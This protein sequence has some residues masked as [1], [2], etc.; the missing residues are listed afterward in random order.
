MTGGLRTTALQSL[1][2]LPP[3]N[4]TGRGSRMI[5]CNHN[6]CPVLHEQ[7]DMSRRAKR[8]SLAFHLRG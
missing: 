5:P 1:Q 6:D 7:G 8:N 3:R 4:R 2:I